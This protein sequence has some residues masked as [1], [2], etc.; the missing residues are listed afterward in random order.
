MDLEVRFQAAVARAFATG[1]SRER[2]CPFADRQS[3]T[4]GRLDQ[5]RAVCGRATR[6]RGRPDWLSVHGSLSG[7]RTRSRRRRRSDRTAGP[8]HRRGWAGSGLVSVRRG[9]MRMWPRWSS[10]PAAI[11][12][13]QAMRAASRAA[14]LGV[15]LTSRRRLTEASTVMTPS[16]APR[17]ETWQRTRVPGE[18]AASSTISRRSASSQRTR[19]SRSVPS[20]SRTRPGRSIGPTSG[21]LSGPVACMTGQGFAHRRF[22]RFVGA[23]PEREAEARGEGGGEASSTEKT[24]AAAAPL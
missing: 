10:C 9:T 13:C 14:C 4:M 20:G 19:Q 21:I 6:D 23:C 16:I 17:P 8:Q 18:G 22:G 2:K 1:L 24:E 15:A 11:R 7:S 12:R 3:D 5:R